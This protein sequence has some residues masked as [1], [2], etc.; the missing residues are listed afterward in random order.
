MLLTVVTFLIILSIL[1]FVHEFGHY[2]V[3]RIIGVHVEEFGFG[4]PPRAWGKKI[5]GTIYSLNWLPIGGFV[6]LAGEDAEEESHK[7][8]KHPKEYFW[9]RTRLERSAILVAGVSMNFLLA[10]SLTSVLL[11]MGIHAP[12][13]KVHIEKILPNTPAEQAGLKEKDVIKRITYK[14]VG[15]SLETKVLTTS[16]DLISFTRAHKGEQIV[17]IIQRNNEEFARG[18]IPRKDFPSGEGPMGVAISDLELK[19][20]PVYAAPFEAIKINIIRARDIVLSLGT[21]V[22][23]LVTL[24]PVGAD[25]AGPIGIAQVT[26]EAV[27]FGFN[28]VLEFMSLLSINLAVINILPFPA[29]D[30][31]RL[32][33]VFV[34]KLLGRKV[35]PTFERTTHQIGMIILLALILLISLND[36]LKITRG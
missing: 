33:F 10:V 28:A 6:K 25:V 34:E 14:T 15:G 1:V 3:A 9:A 20:Y 23:R 31:G 13:G 30:G 11:V 12:S 2:I 36:I 18:L 29:L 5:K 27:K 22:F 16:D 35:R 8:I 24:R 32:A 19:K 26:G 21:L 17:L 7:N 4:L